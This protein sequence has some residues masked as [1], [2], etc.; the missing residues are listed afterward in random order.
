MS[1]PGMLWRHVVINTHGSW[2]HGDGRGF[3]SRRY[4]IHSSGDYRNP[5]PPGEHLGL[6]AH[7]KRKCPDKVTIPLDLRPVVGRAIVEFL[8]DLKVRVLVVA[9]GKVHAHSVVELPVGLREVKRIIGEAKRFSS[10]RVT[11]SIPGTLWSAGGK[12]VPIENDNHL[13]AAYEYD[14]YDQGPW[15]WTWSFRDWSTRGIIGR[16]RPKGA[17][18]KR[19]R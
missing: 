10:C 14:L 15:A 3:R 16:K 1:Q 13:K 11:H 7:H 19:K 12:F 4:R 2:L 18:G 8:R 5:P 17:L 9:V 6:Y